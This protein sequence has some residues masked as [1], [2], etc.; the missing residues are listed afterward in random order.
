MRKS[1]LDERV[2]GSIL[3]VEM[4]LTGTKNYS[5]ACDQ[6]KHQ[7]KSRHCNF[8]VIA[9]CKKMSTVAT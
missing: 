1:N 3:T 7:L 4:M 5:D 9:I 2:N 8:A 6:L